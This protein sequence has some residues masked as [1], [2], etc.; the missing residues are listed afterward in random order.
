MFLLILIVQKIKVQN[1]L[2]FMQLSLKLFSILK[3]AEGIQNPGMFKS[4]I[5][6]KLIKCLF[7]QSNN[8]YTWHQKYLD[9]PANFKLSYHIHFWMKKKNSGGVYFILNYKIFFSRHSR[10]IFSV[11]FE[12]SFNNSIVSIYSSLH[13][14]NFR[15][16]ECVFKLFLRSD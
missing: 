15:L 14:F 4:N 5:D 16:D 9:R 6:Y 10:N 13:K 7:D 8:R 3:A 12:Y 1:L 11:S 2:T